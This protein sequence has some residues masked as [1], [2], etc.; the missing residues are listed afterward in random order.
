MGDELD[1]HCRLLEARRLVCTA[2]CPGIQR[3][4]W[5][6][7]NHV[8]QGTRAEGGV[9]KLSVGKCRKEEKF[10]QTRRQRRLIQDGEI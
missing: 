9:P 4:K 1:L 6:T 7:G 10:H 5:R 8:Y 3:W 2:R